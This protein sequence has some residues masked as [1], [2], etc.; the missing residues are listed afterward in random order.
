GGGG[1]TGGT[2]GDEDYDDGL[3]DPKTCKGC[4]GVVTVPVPELEQVEEDDCNT[5]PEKL[6]E[7]FPNASLTIR[8]T[9]ANYINDYGAAFGIDT[10]EKLCHFLAQTGAETGGFTTLN[11]TEN[12]NYTT[13]ERLKEIYYIFKDSNPNAI[14]PTPYLNNPTALANLVYCCQYGNGNEASG[15]GSLYKGRGIIQLTW[16][17]N[18]DAY[19]EY[20]NSIGYGWSYYQPSNLENIQMHSILSGMWF[21]KVRVLDKITINSD[22]TVSKVTSRINPDMVGLNKRKNYFNQAMETINCQ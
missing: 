22:T 11:A 16:K 17:G 10:K 7:I 9:L 5:S 21:F 15:D 3:V 13:A 4:G 18:Y 8:Q 1:N 14:D 20:L 2:P 19:V 6:L 12:L